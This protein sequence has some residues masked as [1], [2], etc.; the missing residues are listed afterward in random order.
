M[1]GFYEFFIFLIE[2]R[3]YLKEYLF[4]FAKINISKKFIYEFKIIRS[5]DIHKKKLDEISKNKQ[6]N[7]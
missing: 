2:K 4:I 6:K 1:K 5:Y 7:Y 3:K